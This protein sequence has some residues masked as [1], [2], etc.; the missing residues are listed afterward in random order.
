LS[1]EIKRINVRI[2]GMSY[3]LVSSENESYTRSIASKADEMVRRVMQSNPQLSLNMATVLA[4]VNSLDELAKVL[5]HLSIADSS[6]QDYEKQLAEMR[7]ELMRLR[8]QSWEMKKELLR[9]N[10]LNNDY[11]AL[12]ARLSVPEPIRPTQTDHGQPDQDTSGIPAGQDPFMM[13]PGSPPD[14]ETAEAA[15]SGMDEQLPAANKPAKGSLPSEYTSDRLKQTNLEDYLRE[16][17]WPQPLD[18]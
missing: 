1:E 13:D 5:Q 4:L 2:G 6:R 8:E 17:G 15:P 18:P 3:Q 11:E 7:K 10:A 12:L 14:Q 16:N 9:V